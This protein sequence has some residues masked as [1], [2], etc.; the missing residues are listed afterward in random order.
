MKTALITGASSGIGKELAKRHAKNEGNVILVARSEN[1]L[2]EL[3]TSLEEEF[4]IKA[5]VI[6]K[7]LTKENAAKELFDEIDEL[8]L[9]VD[10][11]MNNAGIGELTQFSEAELWRY[12][13]MI[14]L[15]VS[16]LTEMC[17]YF[18]EYVK[19]NNTNGKILNVASTAAF[20]PIPNMAVYAATKAYV[21]SL[22]QSLAVELKKH[23]I[24]VTVLCPGPTRTNF[25][26]DSNV[27]DS[28]E[29]LPI[30]ASAKEVAEYGYKKMLRGDEVAIPGIIN[31]IGANSSRLMPRK[32]TSRIF[33]GIMGLGRK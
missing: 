3:K 21:L 7:D 28:I 16:S 17:Y 9:N 32:V 33:G 1:K 15:N 8:K 11:L 6:V 4:G 20:Q 12:Q 29:S 2:K 13:Q 23:G 25:S 27:S 30:F 18:T 10:Y 14:E 22:S 24:T 31:Q 19:V 26:Q 5:F